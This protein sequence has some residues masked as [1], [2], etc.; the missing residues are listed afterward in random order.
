MWVI[1]TLTGWTLLG[2]L[3]AG[4]IQLF[5]RFL[6][7]YLTRYRYRAIRHS[8]AS[9]WTGLA[10]LEALDQR[11]GLKRTWE[12]MQKL[13]SAE[14][15][16]PDLVYAGINVSGSHEVMA[17]SPEAVRQVT[18]R[19]TV[20][21]VKPETFKN[22]ISRIIPQGLVV[23]EGDEWRHERKL[24]TPLF[25][26]AQIRDVAL[27]AT[28]AQVHKTIALIEKRRNQKDTADDDTEAKGSSVRWTVDEGGNPSTIAVDLFGHLALGVVIDGM[29]GSDLDREW[30]HSVWKDL[31]TANYG[32]LIGKLLLGRLMDYL[33]LPP[34]VRMLRTIRQIRSTI[35]RLIDRRREETAEKGDQA[36]DKGDLVTAMIKAKDPETGERLPDDLIISEALTMLLAGHETTSTILSWLMYFVGRPENT[37]VQKRLQEEADRVLQGE[38]PCAATYGQL[39]YTQ[40]VMKEALRMRP[41]GVQRV[42][43]RDVEICGVKIPKGTNVIAFFI[44][45]HHHP[46]HYPQPHVFDPDRMDPQGQ[47]GWKGDNKTNDAL[48]APFSAGPRA[49]IGQR[50]AMQ[51]V[52]VTMAMLC[53]RYHLETDE[54]EFIGGVLKP[55]G[56]RVKFIK[57]DSHDKEE[58]KKDI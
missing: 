18:S 32:Y 25:H 48:Y 27:P 36:Q 49:C 16:C 56:L 53:Q 44:M 30:M 7:A 33:P 43:V 55:N 47:S 19:D 46:A 11:S 21:F 14:G 9:R 3:A 12:R 28:V 50:F 22:M 13:Y 15:G 39:T 40:Q 5:L 10:T 8:M 2:L 4:V 37:Q 17:M 41:G 29:F 51:E 31:F 45:P 24:L 52:V 20:D 38:D 35:Q 1:L 34:T 54:T 26:Y 57:R 23:S 6:L 58:G 42:A